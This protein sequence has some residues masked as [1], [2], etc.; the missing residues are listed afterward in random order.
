MTFLKLPEIKKNKTPYPFIHNKLSNNHVGQL[1]KKRIEIKLKLNDNH[2]SQDTCQKDN[3]I[4]SL[5][6]LPSHYD[7]LGYFT[8]NRLKRV[9]GGLRKG[10]SCFQVEAFRA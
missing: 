7:T 2:T 3:G 10:S 8:Y 5:T 9:D 6:G 1:Q 4:N